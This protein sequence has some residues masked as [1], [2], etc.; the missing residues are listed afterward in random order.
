MSHKV[1]SCEVLVAGGGIIGAACARALALRGLQVAICDPGPDPAAASAASAGILGPQIERADESLR[2]LGLRARDLYDSLAVALA[3]STGIDIGLWREG[4]ASI[5]FEEAEAEQLREAVAHQRQAGLRCD[6]LEAA[7]VAE[8]FPAAAPCRGALFAP[9]DGAVDAPALTRALREDAKRLGARTFTTRVNRINTI[10][11]R[12]T[13]VEIPAGKIKAEHVV[14][15]A[16]AWSTQIN[17]LPRRLP[18]EPIRGQMAAARWP[19]NM[20]RTVLYYDHAYVLARSGEAIFGS[21]MEHAGFDG[22]VTESGVREIVAAARRLLPQLPL[23]PTRTWAGLR[24]ITPDG[25]PIVGA[26]PDIRRLWYAT[27]HGRNGVLLAGL[28]GEIIGDLVAT[29]NTEVEIASLAPER[30]TS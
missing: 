15:A 18:V 14:I 1:S 16:G 30:F 25:R 8:R 29:G 5:A 17:H 9:E 19:S 20:P 10:L 21:T 7:D 11:G 23:A 24:P 28:T 12:V 27:G 26:D 6:W 4:I 3:D 2:A 13:G 22:S